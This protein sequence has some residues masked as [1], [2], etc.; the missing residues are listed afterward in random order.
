MIHSY[1]LKSAVQKQQIINADNIAV[2]CMRILKASKKGY[3]YVRFDDIHINFS[4][5]SYL[6]LHGYRI[7]TYFNTIVTS[8][9]WN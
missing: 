3:K 8:I 9:L 2:V 5:V 1:K 4:E 7:K 6:T